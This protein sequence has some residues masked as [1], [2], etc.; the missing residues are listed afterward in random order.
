[1]PEKMSREKEVI[2]EALG[3]KIYRTRTEANGMI[4]TVI[5]L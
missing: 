1:M 4:L 2:L 3:A 5:F